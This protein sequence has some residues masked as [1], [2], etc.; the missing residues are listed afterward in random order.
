MV[1]ERVHPDLE[2]VHPDLESLEA[3]IEPTVEVTDL[4]EDRG[5]RRPEP[6][7]NREG[8]G[9][10]CDLGLRNPNL[11]DFPARALP[12]GVPVLSP[13]DLILT[14]IHADPTPWRR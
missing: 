5:L 14:L 3:T 8:G 1:L 11:D 10:I 9:K 6:T 2:R 4:V 7:A 12:T 13:D